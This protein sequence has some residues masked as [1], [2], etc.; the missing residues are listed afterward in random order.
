[1]IIVKRRTLEVFQSFTG[2]KGLSFY[3]MLVYLL[4]IFTDVQDGVVLPTTGLTLPF[5]GEVSFYLSGSSF[6]S[7][8]VFRC[9]YF[10]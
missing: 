4:I 2:V 7:C 6:T 3:P 9:T 10:F 1:M 5:G 8:C